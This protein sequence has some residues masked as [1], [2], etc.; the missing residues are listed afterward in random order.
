MKRFMLGFFQN[1]KICGYFYKE[2]NDCNPSPDC[3]D[4]LFG[5][6]WSEAEPVTKKI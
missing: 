1:D 4:I 6:G 2:N 5:G 3:N